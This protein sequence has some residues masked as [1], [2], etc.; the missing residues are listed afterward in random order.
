MWTRRGQTE[1]SLLANERRRR[2][3]EAPR[4]RDEVHELTEL[5]LEIDEYREDSMIVGARH[6]R[7]IVV[8]HA[9]ALFELPCTDERC[10]GGGH[11]LTPEVMRALR[12]RS[13]RFQGEHVCT[14]EVGSGECRRTLRYAAQASY[15]AAPDPGVAGAPAARRPRA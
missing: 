14:G 9:P 6:T 15:S 7:R 2:E 10:R 13:L 4:L 8:A 12:S 3:D 11:D 5:S 1:A